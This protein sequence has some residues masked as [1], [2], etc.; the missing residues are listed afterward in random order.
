VI[1]GGFEANHGG[2]RIWRCNQAK[3]FERFR[4]SDAP[5]DGIEYCNFRKIADVFGFEVGSAGQ[6]DGAAGRRIAVTYFLT[7]RAKSL[8]SWSFG[9]LGTAMQA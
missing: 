6:A 7:R 4:C 2:G 5:W 8:R 1:A 9:K 3:G